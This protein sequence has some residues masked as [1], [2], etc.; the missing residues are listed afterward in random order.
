[1]SI[2][3]NFIKGKTAEGII[4]RLFIELGY[5]VYQFGIENTFPSLVHRIKDNSDAASECLRLMPD[6]VVY[7]GKKNVPFFL[8]VKFREK[9]Q[10]YRRKSLPTG[11]GLR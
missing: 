9:E 8:E 3:G 11:P 6:F 2:N 4:E 10:L 5:E 7:D 1:M